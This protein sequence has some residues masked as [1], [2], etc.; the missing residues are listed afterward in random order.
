[1]LSSQT[2]RQ[3]VWL[4]RLALMSI[5]ILLAVVLVELSLRT[6]GFLGRGSKF[7]SGGYNGRGYR[8]EREPNNFVYSPGNARLMGK[9]NASRDVRATLG[10][11]EI[12]RAIVSFDWRG[13]RKTLPYSK[14]ATQEHV[15]FLGCSYVWGSTLDDEETI[16]SQ[17]ARK[18]PNHEV[19][20]LALPGAG[21]FEMLEAIRFPR[22]TAGLFGKRGVGIYVLPP[23]HVERDA[24]TIPWVAT[25]PHL[26]LVMEDSEPAHSHSRGIISKL[27]PVRVWF[28]KTLM[29]SFLYRA[30]GNPFSAPSHKDIQRTADFI[31]EIA[32]TYRARTRSDNL[33]VVYQ[34]P[35]TSWINAPIKQALLERGI[36]VVD[37]SRLDWRKI[38]IGSWRYPWDPHPNPDANIALAQL[39]LADLESLQFIDLNHERK[40]LS[41]LALVDQ[42]D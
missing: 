14:N 16:P 26:T 5:S 20:N 30:L 23:F 27:K 21:S 8:L 25:N 40:K 36:T 41:P 33:F 4:E 3:Q 24:A 35:S 39:M 12:A 9:P 19:L 37:R 22:R 29:R 31:A 18:L 13:N 28:A 10:G 1:M 34:F 6:V 7:S 38:L 17:I 11:I 2:T 42:K 15:L 32:A